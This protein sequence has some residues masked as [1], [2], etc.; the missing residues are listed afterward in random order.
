MV[1]SKSAARTRQKSIQSP[2]S[3][4]LI[5]GKSEQ[6]WLYAALANTP[7]VD[8]FNGPFVDPFTSFRYTVAAV[9]GQ[10]V[11]QA[12]LGVSG[13]FSAAFGNG[14]GSKEMLETLLSR[15]DSP[16]Q[17][18]EGDR[19]LVVANQNRPVGLIVRTDDGVTIQRGGQVG[20]VAFDS[21]NAL[22]INM[23]LFNILVQR[24]VNSVWRA[25][26]D[27]ARVSVPISLTVPQFPDGTLQT[28]LSTFEITGPQFVENTRPVAWDDIGGHMIAK[29]MAK[30]VF[31]DL[32]EPD[33][34]RRI[35][36]HPYSNKPFLL[37]GEE[38]TGKTLI[39][40]ALATM[41]VERFG[42]DGFE[43]YRLP[44]AKM[45]V[46]DGQNAA[47]LANTIFGR[48]LYNE[49][50]GIKTLVHLDNLEH[51]TP[52]TPAAQQ[53]FANPQFQYLVVGPLVSV[54]KEYLHTVGTY[55]EHVAIVGESR[56]QRE[57]LPEGVSRGFRRVAD[58]DKL[59]KEDRAE[60]LKIQLALSRHFAASTGVDPFDSSVDS[61]VMD[62]AVA[63][64]GLNGFYMKQALLRVQDAKKAEYV[65]TGKYTPITF[66]E[67]GTSLRHQ[68]IEKVLGGKEPRH[69]GFHA[70]GNNNL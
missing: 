21:L 58:V 57:L 35:G 38:G 5:I 70:A 8:L 42:G 32:A 64:E 46:K 52:Y 16:P 67:L 34:S 13:E 60:V 9:Q 48:S 25:F 22:P 62:L 54:I 7:K 45:L 43:Y 19:G 28:Y 63:A 68:H 69:I 37:T 61:R 6:E 10:L 15:Y 40:K 33:V 56:I 2:A 31:V 3:L 17:F 23:A 26:P 12:Q 66:E 1:G 49:K 41:M 47:A 24:Y 51:L 18:I 50:R 59:S 44:L 14:I 29:E 36:T 27:S 39:V 53:L 20:P 11:F 30:G 55:S 65:S 4:E